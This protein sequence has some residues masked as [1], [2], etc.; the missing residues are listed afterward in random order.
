MGAVFIGQGSGI[1]KGS[2]AMVDDTR[3]AWIGGA[4]VIAGLVF[5]ALALF[6][7]RNQFS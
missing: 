6:R 3:W 4:M 7:D 2:S 5:G 1:L